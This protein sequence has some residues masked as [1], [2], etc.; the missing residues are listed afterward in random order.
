MSNVDEQFNRDLVRLLEA[1]E[2]IALAVRDSDP[3]SAS[4]LSA[5]AAALSGPSDW[6]FQSRAAA[7][8]RGLFHRDGLGDRPPPA[9]AATWD[10]DLKTL[11]DLST[12]HVEARHGVNRG[13]EASSSSTV[14]QR[15]HPNP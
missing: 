6:E 4:Q 5:I 13:C 8:L 11:W 9:G 15:A 3:V 7:S 10:A 2:R 1:C 12:R 14:G